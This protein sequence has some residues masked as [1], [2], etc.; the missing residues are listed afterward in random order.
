M[1]PSRARPSRAGIVA[2]VS[3]CAFGCAIRIPGLTSRD[4]WFDDSWAALP[5][6]V[7]LHDALRMVVTTPLYS[8]AM[9]TWIGVLPQDTWWAQ[10]PALALGV[11]GIAAVWG[12]VRAHGYPAIAAFVAG[13]LVAVGP[14]TVEYSTRVKEYSADLLLACLILWLVER[15]RRAPSSRGLAL[16]AVA[17]IA[18][19]WISASTAAV[20]GGAVAVTILVAWSRP[21]LR[22]QVAAFM[23]AI[24]LAA[25]AVWLAF[26]RQLPGQLRTNWRT[27]GFL[28]G[29]SSSRH[30]EIAF[31]QTFSGLAHGLL[32]VPIPY[33]FRPASIRAWPLALAAI[34]VI[35]LAAVVVPPLVEVLGTKGARTSPTTAAA[36]ATAIAVLGTLTGVA[37]LG[38]GRTD[39]ALYPAFI[40]LGVGVVTALSRRDAAPA[41]RHRVALALTCAF[42]AAAIAFGV[43][44]VATYP[45]TGLRTIVAE[46]Q[47]RFLLR[48]DVV[49]VDGY[50][51]FTWGRR[52]PRSMARLIRAGSRPVADGLSRG[53]R[54]PSRRPVSRVP[55]GRP[56]PAL[57]PRDREARLA[58]RADGRRIL[59]HDT[60]EHL[61]F[62]KPDADGER[63]HRPCQ[64]GTSRTASC[65]DV[66]LRVLGHLRPAL[67]APSRGADERPVASGLG[68]WPGCSRARRAR[69]LRRRGHGEPRRLAS[70]R[71]HWPPR[72]AAAVQ[73]P[74]RSSRGRA[75]SDRQRPR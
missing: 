54:R 6:H 33:T 12:L 24:V 75:S 32:A 19:L 42:A 55:P 39:E 73:R 4:L 5:A 34:T 3:L 49:V 56:E 46:L 53:E 67:R 63:A 45:P 25:A 29:Y 48:G 20:V 68:A 62:A 60:H 21:E 70:S 15:W 58:D 57:A 47:H 7:P 2:V 13:A 64:R 71:L 61:G 44:H 52:G 37:P 27:H 1:Q 10:L 41:R 43:S 28:F 36:A 59:R 51:Q 50:E 35:L 23:G 9:R 40:L 69:A 66:V 17:S 72:R 30:V 8:L 11:A 22:R 14:V 18:A 74:W 16:L 26:L 65:A 38:D 31:Q